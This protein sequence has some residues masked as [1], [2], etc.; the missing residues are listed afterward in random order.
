[1]VN[2]AYDE[3]GHVRCYLGIFFCVAMRLSTATVEATVGGR[4]EE[5]VK[6]A[7][8]VVSYPGFLTIVIVIVSYKSL[9]SV[10]CAVLS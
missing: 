7:R 5:H 1:M 6:S 10:L 4:K 8:Y 9:K 2:G 3:V